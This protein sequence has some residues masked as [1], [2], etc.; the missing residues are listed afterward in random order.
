MA[1]RGVPWSAAVIFTALESQSQSNP[2]QYWLMLAAGNGMKGN[3][4]DKER[5]DEWSQ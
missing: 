3:G 1:R 4:L 5:C 2:I